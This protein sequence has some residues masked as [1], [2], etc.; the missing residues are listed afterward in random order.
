MDEDL[1]QQ[2]LTRLALHELRRLTTQVERMP[3]HLGGEPGHHFIH[4]MLT[5]HRNLCK[6][7][8]RLSREV[9]IS[10]ANILREQQLLVA[11]RYI[12]IEEQL[13]LGLYMLAK[14]ASVRDAAERFQ[15]ST[16]TISKYF[17]KV[18]QALEALSSQ[19]IRPYQSMYETPPEIQSN[20]KYWPFFKDCVGAIDGTLIQSVVADDVGR[21]FRD[22]HGEKTWNV[23]V[24]CSLNMLVTHINVGYEGSAHDTTV[25]RRSLGDARMGF[26]HPP[27]GKYYVVDSAYPNTL[28]Y[29]SPYLVPGLRY[30]LPDFRRGTPPQGMYEQFNYRHSSCRNVI[31]RVFAVLKN[32][33]KVLKSM[34]QMDEAN[35]LKIIVACFTLHNFIRLHDL[36]IPF[37]HQIEVMEQRA[38]HNMYDDNRKIAMD[39]V[40]QQITEAIWDS[41][42]NN[43]EWR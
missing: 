12:S 13:G 22:R 27:S 19:I 21:A 33:W 6:E 2:S 26:P 34:P 36:G 7:Q 9:F 29:L 31:E 38:D 10:L 8:L 32:R 14:P 1:V 25:W 35:Q 23:M 15:H 30:H 5:G 11:G 3:L 17:K 28:G 24:V 16:S 37:T 42:Q 41:M 40:R 20:I 43:P 18:L 4:R 39:S